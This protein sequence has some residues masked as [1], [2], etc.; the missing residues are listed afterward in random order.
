VKGGYFIKRKDGTPWQWD[1]WQPGLAIV[2]F[3]NPDAE[4]WYVD[5]LSHLLDLGVDC[6]KVS[7]EEMV[8][9]NA[10]FT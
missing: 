8:F 6:F 7:I 5:K 3:T 1:L 2:D 10:L 4:K 9:D